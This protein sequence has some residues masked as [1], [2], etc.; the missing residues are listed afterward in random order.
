MSDDAT[1]RDLE[2]EMPLLK[3]LEKVRQRALWLRKESV[4]ALKHLLQSTTFDAKSDVH[5]AVAARALFEVTRTDGE[6]QIKAAIGSLRLESPSSSRFGTLRVAQLL[7]AAGSIPSTALSIASFRAWYLILREI[8]TAHA[9]DWVVGSVR[10]NERGWASAYVTSECLKATLGLERCLLRTAELFDAAA[11]VIKR[12]SLLKDGDISPMWRAVQQSAT[13]ASAFVTM[14]RSVR[15]IAIHL[16]LPASS[17]DILSYLCE[18][19]FKSESV[20]ALESVVSSLDMVAAEAEQYRRGEFPPERMHRRQGDPQGS[21]GAKAQ[22][23]AAR[24]EAASSTAHAVASSSLKRATEFARSALAHARKE[25][26]AGT[27]SVFR[28]IAAAMH[29][30]LRPSQHYLSIVIDRQVTARA[31][32]QLGQWE[33]AELAFAAATYADYDMPKADDRKRLALA[34]QYLCE[35]VGTDGQISPR[36][37]FHREDEERVLIAS[38]A[39]AL[40]A[41]T[42]VLRTTATP[43]TVAI[44]AK[45][46]PHF[47]DRRVEDTETGAT[48][49][50]LSEFGRE[51]TK[52]TLWASAVAV[53][54]LSSIVAALDQSINTIVLRHFTV[55]EPSKGPTLDDLFYPDFGLAAMQDSSEADGIAR[56]SVAVDLQR[57][58]AHVLG[59]KSVERI[60]SI[61]LYGPAGTGKTTLIEAL[62]RTCHAPLVEITPSDISKSGVHAVERRARA[63]FEALTLLTQAIVLFDEFDPVLRRRDPNGASE[64]NIFSFLTPGMLPKLKALNESAK[65]RKFAYALLT[66]YIGSLDDAALRQGRFD[67]KIGIFPPDPLSRLGYLRQVAKQQCARADSAEAKLCPDDDRLAQV[68]ADT[69]GVGMTMLMSA[70]WFR[71]EEF[72][73]IQSQPLGYVVGAAAKRPTEYPDPEDPFVEAKGVRGEGQAA[74]LE[75]LQWGL[76]T[77]WDHDIKSICERVSKPHDS[78]EKSIRSWVVGDKPFR[79]AKAGLETKRQAPISRG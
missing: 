45:L 37:P 26:W 46:L 22:K 77:R 49:G 65:V 41:W 63:V 38:T 56:R 36:R 43:M 10:V 44:A 34:A 47:E 30:R 2:D 20:S 15:G 25:D 68:V 27:A 6:A 40:R 18:G 75:Y 24:Q 1:L 31:T 62:A 42:E 5:Q 60:N 50:W 3:E 79:E 32:D 53:D 14:N 58:R 8:Y 12:A 35:S 19:R 16:A 33:P 54:T 69:G 39:Y 73:R 51:K 76:L 74:E 71:A 48:S 64:L 28:K 52:P 7:R 11:S 29:E 70:G 61:V 21:D 9:D 23:A 67:K 78:L 55:R 59:V 66:N 72:A 57:M 4:E 17:D 13:S